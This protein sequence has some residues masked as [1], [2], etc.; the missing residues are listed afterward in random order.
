MSDVVLLEKGQTVS[1]AQYHG[2]GIWALSI[3]GYDGVVDYLTKEDLRQIAHKLLEVADDRPA[4][5]PREV[6]R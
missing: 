5:P 4:D 1:L 3:S 2:A 6:H